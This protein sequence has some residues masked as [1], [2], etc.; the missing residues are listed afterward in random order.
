MNGD[1]SLNGNLLFGNSKIDSA[2]SLIMNTPSSFNNNIIVNS[3]GKLIMNGDASF[4]GN[5]Y[6]DKSQFKFDDDKK[7]LIMNNDTTFNNPVIINGNFDM[8]SSGVTSMYSRT[9]EYYSDLIFT[10]KT[11]GGKMII[12]GETVFNG[13]VSFNNI[14]YINTSYSNSNNILSDYRIKSN[15]RELSDTDFEID[16][17]NPVFYTNNN[18]GKEDIGFIAH[19]LQEH[20]P[21]LVNGEKDGEKLQSV[22]YNGLIGMLVRELQVLKKKVEKLENNNHL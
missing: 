10:S 15:V 2:G 6:F 8:Y 19:E 12:N 4:N 14:V 16:S 18:S 21:F 11:A 1:A 3:P 9:T 22:N 7:V 17:L 20:F 13:D 5:F